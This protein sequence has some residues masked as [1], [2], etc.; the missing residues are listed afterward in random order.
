M[1]GKQVAAA[2]RMTRLEDVSWSQPGCARM[3]GRKPYPHF[4]QGAGTVMV[5]RRCAASEARS[6][7]FEDRRQVGQVAAAARQQPVD[8]RV[9]EGH[10][11]MPR[12][13][14]RSTSRRPSSS[15]GDNAMRW[16]CDNRERRSGNTNPRRG[17]RV[18]GVGQP[19]I[20]RAWLCRSNSA[21]SSSRSPAMASSPSSPPV[22][23]GLRVPAHRASARAARPAAGR[24]RG[25]RTH[26]ALRAGRAQEMGL[27]GAA[28]AS[29]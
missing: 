12:A 21:T 7:R 24:R 28:P 8:R 23:S 11:A 10:A 3:T 25:G 16:H 6:S 20:A 14:R 9:V 18:G 27:A 15:S 13:R 4:P 1:P 29:T 26:P 2:L 22:A 5:S 17:R 19:A